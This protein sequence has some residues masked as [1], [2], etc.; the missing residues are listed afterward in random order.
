M[1][2]GVQI[3]TFFCL[4]RCQRGGFDVAHSANYET[5]TY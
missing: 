4:A 2:G 3:H 5:D 1:R